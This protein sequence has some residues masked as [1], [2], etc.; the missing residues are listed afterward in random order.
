MIKERANVENAEQL[1]SENIAANPNNWLKNP[2]QPDEGEHYIRLQNGEDFYSPQ[3]EESS[4][5]ANKL[6]A[7]LFVYS[8]YLWKKEQK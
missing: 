3:S 1:V 5:L 7:K 6:I 2:P 4:S 8:D